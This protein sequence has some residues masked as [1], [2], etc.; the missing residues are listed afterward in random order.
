MD[1]GSSFTNRKKGILGYNLYVQGSNFKPEPM[2][3]GPGPL[4]LQK[5]V[6]DMLK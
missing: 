3:L 4:A 1:L 6:K 2:C 5:I